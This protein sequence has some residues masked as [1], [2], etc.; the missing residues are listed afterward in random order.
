MSSHLVDPAQGSPLRG[1]RPSG[2]QTSEAKA[3]CQNDP[4]TP[5]PR[6]PNRTTRSS[7]PNSSHVIFNPVVRRVA[8]NLTAV[9]REHGH[10]TDI[11]HH[12]AAMAFWAAEALSG[13]TDRNEPRFPRT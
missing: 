6:L 7:T 11:L 3:H 13:I 10:F 1:T 9:R 12:N 8:R 4:A 5:K 2:H